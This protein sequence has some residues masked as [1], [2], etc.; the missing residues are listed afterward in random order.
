MISGAMFGPVRAAT[1]RPG[2]TSVITC[3]IRNSDPCSRPL[4][5][6]TMGIHGWIHA[7]AS[8]SVARIAELGTPTTSSSAWR[9]ACSRSAVATSLRPSGSPGRYAELV[10]SL[11]IS[12]ATA[13]L[14]AQSIVG[15]RDDSI[16]AMV[17]PHEPAPS[18]VTCIGATLGPAGGDAGR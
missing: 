14:R 9:D 3:V 8:L 17:V 11:L 16:D 15:W 18:T 6:L 10:E 7:T 13:G 5:R 1:G 4:A 2:A 12:S